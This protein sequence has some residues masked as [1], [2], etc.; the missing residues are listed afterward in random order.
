MRLSNVFIVII[1]ILFISCQK[2]KDKIK[3]LS[4][5]E[6]SKEFQLENPYR[7]SDSYRDSLKKEELLELSY[8]YMRA[9]DSLHFFQINNEARELSKKL[10]DTNAIAAS[11]WDLGQFY[12][13]KDILDSAYYYFNKAKENYSKIGELGNTA[14]LLLNMASIH[15]QMVNAYHKFGY[16]LIEVPKMSVED[17]VAFIL[18]S[19]I[20]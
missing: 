16:Q 19:V 5:K 18:D 6:N 7:I 14:R 20:E 2:R 11:Y 10:R 13:N 8:E 17:R 1:L 3:I 12:Y 15:Q 4:N 9:Q